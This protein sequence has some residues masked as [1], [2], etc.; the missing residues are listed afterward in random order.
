MLA[1]RQGEITKLLNAL[2]LIW[3]PLLSNSDK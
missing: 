1:D 2:V 3:L